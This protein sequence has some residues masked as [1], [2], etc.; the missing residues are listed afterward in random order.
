MTDRQVP[1]CRRGLT[2]SSRARRRWRQRREACARSLRPCLAAQSIM[3]R[4]P[5]L[6]FRSGILDGHVHLHTGSYPP[7]TTRR[8]QIFKG[9]PRCHLHEQRGVP[10]VRRRRRLDRRKRRPRGGGYLT[11]RW[12]YPGCARCRLSDVPRT[13][14]LGGRRGRELADGRI[15]RYLQ[16]I[17]DVYQSRA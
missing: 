9:Q 7:T 14:K 10:V 4:V 8:V 11:T 16:S 5:I 2:R 6:P 3:S 13:T 1:W 12:Q 17:A 15:V